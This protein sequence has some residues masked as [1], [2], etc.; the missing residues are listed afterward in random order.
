[1]HKSGFGATRLGNI[2]RLEGLM[3]TVFAL[4][5]WASIISVVL[6]T[7]YIFMA[8]LPPILK[9]GISEFIL[10]TQWKPTAEEPKFGIFPMIL[11]SFLGMA[12]AAAI[13]VP[14]GLF[15][16]ILLALMAPKRLAAFLR[17]CIE[18]MAGIPS[19]VYGFFGLTVIVPFIRINLGSPTG[20]SLLAMIII[21]SAMILPTIVS[22]SETALR[23]VPKEYMEGALALGA[24]RIEAIF[25]VM[26][27]AAGSGIMASAVLGM[28]RAVGETMAVIMVCGNIPRIPRSLLDTI[29]PMTATIAKDMSYAGP[30]HQAALFGIGAVLFLFIVAL[31]MVLH[32]VVQRS[33]EGKRGSP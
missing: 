13:G 26:I 14:V 28:G 3:E 25:K 19:V 17:G 1:M 31:N 20:T 8:G 18:L 21:L 22:L 24:S 16:A 10:G 2:R 4:C 7:A 32:V 12:G 11:A 30:F 27:P 23:A 5:G 6:I 29:S 15:T 33:I 9:T